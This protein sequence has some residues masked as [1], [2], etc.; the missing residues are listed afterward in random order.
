MNKCDNCGWTGKD[1]EVDVDSDCRV[2]AG[3]IMP[4]GCCPECDCYVY[5]WPDP[6]PCA[7]CGDKGYQIFSTYEFEKCDNCNR[8]RNTWKALEFYVEEGD[9]KVYDL[10]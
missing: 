6:I 5:H 1:E 4:A 9:H 8:F 10:R 2:D 3:D 7:F